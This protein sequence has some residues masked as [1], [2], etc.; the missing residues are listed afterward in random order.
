MDQ[1][2]QYSQKP[3]AIR[4]RTRMTD[5]ETKWRKDR[6]R[7]LVRVRA[8]AVP[9]EDSEEKYKL[10]LAEINVVRADA[11][12]P[13]LDRPYRVNA[14]AGMM[15]INAETER[16]QGEVL[17]QMNLTQNLRD[18]V[19]GLDQRMKQMV[20][21]EQGRRVVVPAGEQFT[22]ETIHDHF[23]MPAEG[24]GEGGKLIGQGNGR[25]R[26]RLRY[27]SGQ[28]RTTGRDRF[29]TFLRSI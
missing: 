8:G 23:W 29:T 26:P 28:R 20:V 19:R 7:L 1:A 17:E 6:A 21:E 11:G 22:L 27:G 18:D 15:A 9:N 4:E 5:I 25:V 12:L 13:E 14:F 3:G 2:R 16:L 24:N 10:S